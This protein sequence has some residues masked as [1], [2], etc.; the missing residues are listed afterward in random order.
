MSVATSVTHVFISLNQMKARVLVI[1]A[2]MTLTAACGNVEVVSP[3]TLADDAVA[4]TTTDEAPGAPT[5]TIEA[6]TTTQPEATTTVPVTTT[7]VLDIA[8]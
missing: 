7:T 1:T 3:T 4:T 8:C 6:S 5:T 2:A